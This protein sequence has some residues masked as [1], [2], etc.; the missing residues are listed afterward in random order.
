MTEPWQDT[1]RPAAERVD[2]LLSE[3]T[4]EE[5][6]GQLGSRWVGQHR[7]R[8]VANDMHDAETP[9]SPE[10]SPTDRHEQRPVAPMED[11]FAAASS[12]PLAEASRH[13]L[14]HLTRVYGSVPFSPCLLYTSPSPRDRS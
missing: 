12:A 10:S 1:S 2:L 11:A 14:G 5:K 8:W 4:L 3:M 9:G 6:V 7:S 13:G